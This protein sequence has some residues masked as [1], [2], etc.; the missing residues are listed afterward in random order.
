MESNSLDPRQKALQINLDPKTYGS[1]AEIGAGQEVAALFFK[2][3]AA[4]GTIAKT[5]SAYD[6]TFSDAIYGPEESGRYVCESRLMKMLN[7][8]FTL[9]EKRLKGVR[10]A[11]TLFFAFADTVVGLNYKKTN[12]G[13]GWMGMRFQLTPDSEPNDVIIHVN[14]LDNDTLLQQTAVGIIG[15][16]LVYAC[17][18]YHNNP[19]KMITSLVDS[20]GID[21]IEV[22]MMRLSGPDFK[23]V[24]SRLIS[25]LLVKNKLTH[26]ALFGPKGDV[27][28]P[29]EV[30][31]KK[32]IL[33]L[34][35][36]FRPVTHVNMDMLSTGFEEF[37][38]DKDVAPDK[39]IE[40]CELTLASLRAEGQINEK[41]FLDRAEIL[42]SLGQTVLIS[43]YPE[44][45]RLVSYLSGFTKAKIG[46][47]IGV[48][49]LS[50]IFNEKYY[51]DL[52]GGILE[53][54]A[55][56]F[57]RNVKM[58]AYPAKDLSTG[59]LKTCKNFQLPTNLVDLYEYLLVNDKIEDIKNVQ[60]DY[61]NIIS[62]KVLD[63]IKKGEPGWESM[64]PEIVA[65][66]V[67]EKKLFSY[68]S[69]Q[70]A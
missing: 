15:V 40:V 63:M 65:S 21:R 10:P 57:S 11:D 62:D 14:M 31:Y 53:S 64:V 3:G 43:D 33:V 47:I 17:F 26:A 59:E 70:P 55:T 22:D 34:R 18:Y 67:K 56:L 66:S 24:D 35:G 6:M 44:Y 23:N 28:Q 25:L 69:P 38:N 37:K 30:F 50:D 36:R 19:E 61:L 42:C 1:F 39:I 20:L 45:F 41:D 9:I 5:I 46:I 49:G 13:H 52:K 8:E 29:S 68:N 2:A 51:M 48:L 7:R 58:Y 27:L 16:N 54:F 32:N 4:S 60:L 12:K